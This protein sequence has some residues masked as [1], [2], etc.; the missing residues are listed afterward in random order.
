M[1]AHLGQIGVRVGPK[2]TQADER[3][4]AGIVERD[5]FARALGGDEDLILSHLAEPDEVGAV[6][7]QLPDQ[8]APL[9]RDQAVCAGVFDRDRAAGLDR[10]LAG[11]EELLAVDRAIYDPLIDV[12][13]RL[14][15]RAARWVPGNCSS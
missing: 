9:H 13:R 5:S 1:V 14:A 11:A 6:D 8:A 12:T 2:I 7:G 4:A 10:K 15:A 3:F